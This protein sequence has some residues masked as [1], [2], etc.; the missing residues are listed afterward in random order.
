MKTLFIKD[1]KRN[2]SIN[3]EAFAIAEF[4]IAS[5]KN[6]KPYAN[7]VLMDKTGSIQAKIWN[8]SLAMMDS[9]SFVQGSIVKVNAKV[10][11]YKGKLQCTVNSMF[12]IQEDKLDDFMPCSEYDCE[13]MMRELMAEIELIKNEDLRSVLK[14]MFEDEEFATN[15]KYSPAGKSV[16]HDFRSG[17]L[18]HVLEMIEIAKSLQKYYPTVDYDILTAGIILHDTG[19]FYE[20]LSNGIGTTYTKKGMLVGH[21]SL[22]VLLFDKFAR[23]KIDENTYFNIVHLILSHH[24][25]LQF[26]SPAVP[27][28]LEAVILSSI[29]RLSSKA[30]AAQKAVSQIPDDQESGMPVPWL[31]GARFFR[32]NDIKEQAN[33]APEPTEPEIADLNK[34]DEETGDI[35]IFQE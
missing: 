10:D 22:G 7:I 27:S 2:Q 21:I 29:D 20:L 4:S 12:V 8:E 17:M 35:L 9:K 15:Y 30:R 18:Q 5:D 33:L 31:E 16:H 14:S 26:G 25:E 34:T 6:G 1:L 24:G 11:E 28:T 19:K 3:S 23:D 32:T 13:E